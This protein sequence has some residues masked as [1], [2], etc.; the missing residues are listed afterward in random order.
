MKTKVTVFETVNAV[1]FWETDG[2]YLKKYENDNRKCGV[3][4]FLYHSSSIPYY[5]G[6]SYNMFSRLNDHISS[7]KGKGYYVPKHP[8]KLSSLSCF[9]EDSTPD[10]F[11]ARRYNNFDE[12][13]DNTVKRLLE[14]TQ[15]LFSHVEAEDSHFHEDM[16]KLAYDAE[17][18][19]YTNLVERMGIKPGWVGDG[20]RKKDISNCWGIYDELELNIEYDPKITVQKMNTKL[21]V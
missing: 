3:Y 12:Y 21:L 16:R 13:F 8:E 5:I 17:I 7:Y 10:T 15:I 9:L 20:G 14:H 4:F 2:D 11:Y 18:R 6:T 19:L 1:D